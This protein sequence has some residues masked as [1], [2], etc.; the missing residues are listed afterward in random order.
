MSDLFADQPRL[1]PTL[2]RDL[3]RTAAWFLAG[4]G[5]AL[6]AGR[7]PAQQWSPVPP[8]A[9][10]SGAEL[11]PPPI[12]STTTPAAVADNSA[13]PRT[14]HPLPEQISA[15]PGV[16]ENLDVV[17]HHSQLLIARTNI[18]RTAVADPSIV[19]VVQFSPSE[20]SI[21]G[22]EL[23]STTLT[24]WFDNS[25][26]P[27][28]YQVNTLRDPSVDERRRLDYSKL[29][30]K[31]AI[32][33]PNSKVYLIPFSGKLVVKGQAHDS[34]EAAK[35]VQIIRGEVAVPPSVPTEFSEKRAPNAQR[36]PAARP[37]VNKTD[38]AAAVTDIVNLLEVPGERQVMLRVRIAELNR[39]MLRSM[40]VNLNNVLF[41]RRHTVQQI[42]NTRRRSLAGI[43]ENGEIDAAI[44]ALMSNGTATILSEPVL[45]VVSG[46]SASFL[47]GGEFAVPTIVGVEGVGAQQTTFHGFGTSLVVTPA[48]LDHELIRMKITPE[49][50]QLD[51]ANTVNGIPGVDTRRAETTVQLREGQTIVL[52]GLISR[53]SNTQTAKVGFWGDAP[54]VG[55]L[56]SGKRS[57]LEE[58]E[59]LILVTPE[60]VRPMDCEQVPPLPG[61]EV[62]LPNNCEFYKL[63]RTEGCPEPSG[64]QATFN[65]ANPGMPLGP[66]PS[67]SGPLNP[68]GVPAATPGQVVPQGPP[69]PAPPA[70]VLY[71]PSP[72]SGP[73]A[74]ASDPLGGLQSANYSVP[75]EI[76]LEQTSASFAVDNTDS[77]KPASTPP[78][79]KWYQRPFRSLSGSQA[80]PQRPA[81][82]PIA[83]SSDPSLQSGPQQV[84]P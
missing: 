69:V 48:V 35:I 80:T 39:S 2:P 46:H 28:I 36:N 68:A 72:R 52:A 67:H 64:Y 71:R 25:H 40:G 55:P 37:I 19:D 11:P 70:G 44:H 27:L 16:S 66:Q 41:D 15:M 78:P 12:A 8:A 82:E 20:L 58:T 24:L 53:Q 49:F 10:Q 45:T 54:V 3:C 21:I 14:G 26:Q 76:P 29:E 33:F 31:L 60:I 4:C 13:R 63:G 34:E 81:D 83:G 73:A 75:S 17:Q 77:A 6:T 18:V 43:F 51:S 62:T 1:R 5:I 50:S 42:K 32:L 9:G 59:L 56:F 65:G 38:E 61:H 7:L 84:Q 74:A 57:M 30:R 47:S 23:G 22:L 79:L